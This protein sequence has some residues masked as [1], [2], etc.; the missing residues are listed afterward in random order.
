[1]STKLDKQALR[2]KIQELDIDTEMKSQLLSLVNEQKKYGLVWE[3]KPEEVEAQL[4][5]QLPVFTE[6]TERAII[7]DDANAP[8]HIIIEGDNLQAL[9]TLSYTHA[10]KIDVI[11]IDPPYNTGNKNF[12]YNDS[13]V[14]KAD[15]YHH[16]KWLSFMKKRLNIAK[17]LLSDKGVIFI[18]IDDNEQAQLKL[19]CDEIFDEKNNVG[20]MCRAT[21]TNTGQGTNKL[22]SSFDYCLIYANENFKL[23]GV[24]LTEKDLK[25]FKNKDEGGAYSTIQLRKT[26]S[27]DRRADRP[28]MFYPVIAPDGT[29]VFPFGP[30]NYL[31]R[32]RVVKSSYEKLLKNNMIVWKE[33]KT[34]VP[35]VIDGI[36]KSKWNPYVKYYAE[37][38]TK[39]ISNLLLDID[40]NKKASFEIKEIFGNNVTFDYPK[41]TGFIKLLEYIST[42]KYS[43]ILDFFAGSG[44]TLHATMQLNA[45]DGGHRQCILVTNN[46]NKICENV[47]YE[48]NKRV[49][50]G[51]TTPKGEEVE[52]LKK[53]NLRYYKTEFVSSEQTNKNKQ[54]LITT[55]TSLLCIK[56]NV[57]IEQPDFYGKKLCKNDVRYFDD[58]KTRMLIIYNELYVPVIAEMLKTI[59]I[60]YKI[61]IYVFSN[62]RYVFL[63]TRYVFSN[64][65]N[66]YAG[67]FEEVTD[68]V[69]L[70]ALPTAIYDAC[71]K[72]IKPN[73]VD[74]VSVTT[75]NKECKA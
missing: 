31:S 56:N 44:T 25:R 33:S 62:T 29:E 26:G 36:S 1:M 12:V 68:K 46:E 13:F 58:G 43:T 49:I 34:T 16:S 30:Y 48:R 45:E 52:G 69:T 72:V 21:G 59:D 24:N 15:G 28:N 18:S 32:W 54:A 73:N 67:N 61:L 64:T 8:N 75:D 55:A 22:G 42:N 53:N 37:G 2:Q 20:I 9:T 63:N 23:K 51:Y 66:A 17:H 10:G 19:L 11:Y 7:S 5:E 14:D 50:N 70:C 27:A 40:G 47:T 6:V 65:N 71:K 4:K 39:H 3:D 35:I 57:Y 74:V 60:D 38:K 41:P